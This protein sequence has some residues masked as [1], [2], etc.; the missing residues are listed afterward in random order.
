M[1]NEKYRRSIL[2]TRVKRGADIGSD[3]LLVLSK[4]KLK[5]KRTDRKRQINQRRY[6]VQKLSS[7]Q[8]IEKF[9]LELRKRFAVSSLTMG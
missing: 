8:H 2:D 6:D 5:M 4:I 1:V 3:H 7:R 9:K